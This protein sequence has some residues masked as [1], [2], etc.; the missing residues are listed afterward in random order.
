LYPAELPGPKLGLWLLHRTMYS[1]Y[2]LAQWCHE[3]L[4]ARFS[5]AALH[6]CRTAPPIMCATIVHRLFLFFS[7][8]CT[9]TIVFF[10]ASI[11][12]DAAAACVDPSG[13][14]DLVE[15]VRVTA[16]GDIVVTDGRTFRLGGIAMI[17][18]AATAAIRR[19]V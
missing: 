14:G 2:S 18:D 6:D 10:G 1:H 11:G 12:L 8:L 3:K 17:D 4:S 5:T 16:L 15:V 7:R 13:P 9:V 19:H